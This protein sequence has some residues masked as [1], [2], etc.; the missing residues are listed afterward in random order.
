MGAIEQRSDV[1][2]AMLKTGLYEA[3]E[4][5]YGI[6]PMRDVDGYNEGSSRKHDKKW[7]QLESVLK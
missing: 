6:N 7:A 5:D 4:K 1:L 3:R 2:A